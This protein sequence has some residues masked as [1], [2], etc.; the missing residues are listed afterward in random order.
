MPGEDIIF[1]GKKGKSFLC[2]SWD[3]GNFKCQEFT[4]VSGNSVCSHLK[5]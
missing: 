2:A 3:H 1:R 4:T 5:C